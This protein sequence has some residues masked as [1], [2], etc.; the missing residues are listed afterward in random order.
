MPT[1]EYECEH[2]GP[3]EAEQRITEPPLSVCPLPDVRTRVERFHE[4]QGAGGAISWNRRPFSEHPDRCVCQ[5]DDPTP[6]R[7]HD[8]A[9]PGFGSCA[10]CGCI[11]YTPAFTPSCDGTVKRVIAGQTG[12]VL[13]GTGW[14]KDGY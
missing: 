4:F 2:C 5:G 13:K 12:F 10:R 1:Y 11:E 8:D 6:H 9:R 7:H 14:F 3:F